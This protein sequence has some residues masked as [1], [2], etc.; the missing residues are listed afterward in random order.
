MMSS[1]RGLGQLADAV[2]NFLLAGPGL[3]WRKPRQR[4]C[5][6][7]GIAAPGQC[8]SS[9]AGPQKV[10]PRRPPQRCPGPPAGTAPTPLI[11]LGPKA[12][13]SSSSVAL[14]AAMRRFS[15]DGSRC[16]GSPSG[17]PR[18]PRR[19]S[20]SGVRL[21][22][23][24]ALQTGCGLS[25]SR[26][27]RMSKEA[28]VDFPLPESPTRAVTFPLGISKDT[29]RK[30]ALPALIAK[31]HMLHADAGIGFLLYRQGGVVGA[32][33][34]H[35]PA[36]FPPCP[37]RTHLP[38]QSGWRSSTAAPNRKIQRTAAAPSARWK[39]GWLPRL[40]ARQRCR[41]KLPPPRKSAHR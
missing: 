3:R 4:G 19:R 5:T 38:R 11:A 36:V 39:M 13:N 24:P 41:W 1:V 22:Q 27:K 6:P 18:S 30:A 15:P 31:G 2:P 29:S 20:S 17:A 32:C 40:A 14:G 9:A 25:P 34:V 10:F 23:V 7:P 26:R 12:S 16:T 21:D 37:Q 33:G 35:G 28:M 8:P